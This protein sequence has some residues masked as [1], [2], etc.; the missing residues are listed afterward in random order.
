MARHLRGMAAS[1]LVLAALCGCTTSVSGRAVRAPGQSPPGNLRS[2]SPVFAPI[3]A[4]DLLLQNGDTTPLGPATAMPVGATYF[5]SV[6]PPEC[7]AALLFKG[8]PLPPPRAADHAE[9]SYQVAGPALYAESID[10]YDKK[11]NPHDVVWKSFGVVSKC[12]G[13]AV[14][15]SPQGDFQPMRL[16]HFTIASDGVLV[17]T[18]TRPDWTCDYGLVVL[19]RTVLLASV[20]DA[21]SGFPMSEWAAKRRAQLDSR[22]T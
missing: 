16:S 18:M 19:A 4:R 13:D 8:S 17:W 7:A 12:R 10:N 20:C 21:K 5:T 3:P 2:A 1:V 14:G 11:L 9:S 6:T 15:H 22:T